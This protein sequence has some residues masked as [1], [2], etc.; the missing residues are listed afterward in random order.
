MSPRRKIGIMLENRFIDQEII[1]YSN[2]FEEE[3]LEVVFLTRLWGQPQLTFKGIE[4]GMHQTVNKSFEDLSDEALREYAAV[5][6]PAGYVAEMLRYSE[7]PKDPAPAVK[8]IQKLMSDKSIIKGAICHSLWI[9]DPIPK[10]IAG[11]QV[12]CHNNIYGSVVNA[13]GVY[14]DQ[15]IVIDGDLITA[16]TGAMFAKFSRT[17]INEVSRRQQS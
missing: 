12:T 15:D 5:I 1:Y 17:I 7:D 13:G 16:R 9:F 8:F 14:V 4:L 11:R 6:V 10:S 3:G 2:R